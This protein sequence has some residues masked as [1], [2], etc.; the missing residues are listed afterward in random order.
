MENLSVNLAAY[1]SG[2]G[3]DDDAMSKANLSSEQLAELSKA[4]EAG[5]LQG[6]DLV[7]SQTNGGALKT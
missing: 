1:N 2:S 4:L 5:S 3:F 6:G 7:G